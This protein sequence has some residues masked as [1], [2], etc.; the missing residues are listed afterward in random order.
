MN[1]VLWLPNWHGTKLHAVNAEDEKV[2]RAFCGHIP[3]S[4]PYPRH[5]QGKDVDSLPKCEKCLK[6]YHKGIPSHDMP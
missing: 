5:L 2:R 4:P 6:K 3:E 1:V